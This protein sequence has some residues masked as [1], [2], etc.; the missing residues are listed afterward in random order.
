M[1]KAQLSFARANRGCEAQQIYFAAALIWALNL[2]YL[3][4]G[5]S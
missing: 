2:S 5:V 4:W 3:I 1:S